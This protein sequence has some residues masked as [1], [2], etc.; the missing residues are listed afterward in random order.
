MDKIND[1]TING[2]LEANKELLISRTPLFESLI[3]LNRKTVLFLIF[4]LTGNVKPNSCCFPCADK[5]ALWSV[6]ILH[7]IF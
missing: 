4:K 3:G 2:I 1:W 7:F 5:L 6:K